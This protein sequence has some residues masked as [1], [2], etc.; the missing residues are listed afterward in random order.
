MQ[1]RFPFPVSFPNSVQ[2]RICARNTYLI[3]TL[4]FDEKYNDQI[5]LKTCQLEASFFP[6]PTWWHVQRVQAPPKNRIRAGHQERE[7][8]VLIRGHQLEPDRTFRANWSPTF[9][10]AASKGH[11]VKDFE[12][13]NSLLPLSPTRLTTEA[14]TGLER[15]PARATP[16]RPTRARQHFSRRGK[17]LHS[18][19]GF[20]GSVR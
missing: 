12:E 15:R 13:T 2:A 11:Q 7:S 17:A 9:W 6:S 4:L 1:N 16:R 20:Q 18:V 8:S 14:Q 10:Y 3:F 5:K 19:R